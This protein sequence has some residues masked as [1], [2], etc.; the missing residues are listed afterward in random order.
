MNLRQAFPI[1][2]IDEDFEGASAAGRGMR[3]LAAEI[4]KSG[5]RTASGIG[6]TDA[7]RLATIFNSESC[8][9][10]SVDGA[11]DSEGQ[12]QA[13]EELLAE[14]RARNRRLP[15][16]LFGDV[17]TAEQVPTAILRHANA[18]MRLFEDSAEFMAR[19]IVHAAQAY[20]DS[21]APPMFKALLEY[22]QNGSYSWHTPGHGGGIGFR[23]SPVG[24]L[25]YEFFGENTLRSDVSVSV[26]S[27]GS[28]LD[29][30]GPIAAGERNASRI[31]GTDETLFVVGGTST[32]NKIVWHGMVSRG[33]LVLC[34]RNCHK[35]ILHSLIMTGATP[36]YLTPSRNG[37]GIIGPI[38]RDQFTP[39]SIAKKV[40]ASPFAAETNGK[41]RLM[42]MTNSTYDGICYNI[43]RVKEIV[44]DTVE[45]LHFDEAW[46]AYANFHEFYDGVHAISSRDEKRAENA[47]T[48]ATQSTH[49]LLAALSQASMIHVQN[50]KNRKL[51]M[52]RFNEAFMMHTSTS[53]QYGIIASCDVAAAMMEQPGGR[54]IV[55]EMIDEAMN[56]RR[57]M[58]VAGKDLKD[59]W[60]F[61]VW[62]PD[63]VNKDEVPDRDHWV[64]KPGDK[65]HGFKD[66]A[67]NHAMLDPVKVTILSP[68]LE[69]DGSMGELG[70]PAGVVTRF[71]SSRRIEIEKTGLYSFLVLFSLGI[72]KGKWSTLVTELLNFKDLYD[73]NAPLSNVFPALVESHPEV[74]GAMGL[75]DLCTKIHE[76]YRTHDVPAAQSHMYTELPEMAQRPAET[77]E[78]LIRGKVESVEIDKLM[79]RTLAVMIVPYPPGIPL[80]M[81]GERITEKTRAIQDYLLFARGFDGRFPGFETDI[82]GLRFEVNPD[83][84]RRYLVDCVVE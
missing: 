41:V 53:P 24:Q 68:G 65:W 30:T 5:F 27:L 4:E 59:S 32:S 42:V 15:I 80:I 33:D 20:I 82:H 62:Q 55:K 46:F 1:A 56:F 47:I 44:G 71:L 13:L 81:P 31:F 36:I 83:G 29:H 49:K 17:R 26:G 38:S 66:L 51:D 64:L 60:W 70:I 50:G 84:S 9:L 10:V 22:T 74:Y 25:F 3:Q 61:K 67:K 7:L 63:G 57:A 2:I 14:K 75:K 39:E 77:Y 52:A 69:A 58:K 40:A 16:F 12:W 34:D 76:E 54:A 8:W 78:R 11:E 37:L 73:A 28:L 43:D 23:K 19:A 48:F 6:Y 18:F 35:S 72:T 79:G 21:L 45:V